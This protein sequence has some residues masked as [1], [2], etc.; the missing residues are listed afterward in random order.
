MSFELLD[1]ETA[2]ILPRVLPTGWI[3]HPPPNASAFDHPSQGLR[4]IVTVERIDGKRWIHLSVSR[5][6]RIPSWDDLACCKRLFMGAERKAIQIIPPESE[7][8]NICEYCLH[9][10]AGLDGDQLPD[11]RREGAL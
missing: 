2:E 7:H 3:R 11:F 8:V 9:L 1:T 6:R 4:A 5:R 10:W